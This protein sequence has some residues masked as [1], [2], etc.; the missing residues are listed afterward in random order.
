METLCCFLVET[1]QY[2]FMSNSLFNSLGNLHLKSFIGACGSTY[3]DSIG[4]LKSC[5]YFCQDLSGSQ[6]SS[7]YLIL[8]TEKRNVS[9]TVTGLLRTGEKMRRLSG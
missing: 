8:H 4:T 1:L 6:K 7:V 5:E 2:L 3:L 9:Q